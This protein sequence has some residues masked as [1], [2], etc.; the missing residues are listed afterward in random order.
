[1]D[2]NQK[3]RII[4]SAKLPLLTDS[5]LPSLEDRKDFLD[6]Q[7]DEVKKVI[8]RCVFEIEVYKDFMDNRDEAVQQ[9]GEA[10]FKRRASE[11]RSYHLTLKTL[12]RVRAELEET[13][14]VEAV[15]TEG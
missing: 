6:K 12:K 7:I 10:E 5:V 11:L 13:P 14:T 3:Q 8:Y 15:P 2:K 9:A 1:M 4:T